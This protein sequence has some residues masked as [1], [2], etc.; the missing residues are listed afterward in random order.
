M[1][2]IG[3]MFTS[4]DGQ[5][6]NS[7]TGDLQNRSEAFALSGGLSGFSDLKNDL[8]GG[9]KKANSTFA[10]DTFA[11]LTRQQWQDFQTDILPYENKLIEFSNDQGAALDASNRALGRVDTAFDRQAGDTQHKLQ[12]LGLTLNADE[13]NAFGRSNSLA[14]AAAQVQGANTAALQTRELQQ[15][16]MGNPTP[17]IQGMK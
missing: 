13:Q 10:Q 6:R 5:N 2:G 9:K 7:F 3:D 14:R 17:N 12:S 16:V 4:N 15:A 8:F 1:S 11:A